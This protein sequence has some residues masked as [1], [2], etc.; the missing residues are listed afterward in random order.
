[1]TFRLELN[2]NA[3]SIADAVELAQAAEAAG[4]YRFGCW[5]SPALH[6]D[7]GPTLMAV[8]LNTSRIKIGPNVTNP[9]TRHPV[10]TASAAALAAC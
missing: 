9:L 4:Y 5:D 6:A 2:T 3:R 10:V 8:A 1:L 7:C